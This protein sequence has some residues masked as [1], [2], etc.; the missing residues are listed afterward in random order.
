MNIFVPI[1]FEMK[2]SHKISFGSNIYFIIHS[3][4]ILNTLTYGLIWNIL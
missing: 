2:T 3:S 4:T 1:A